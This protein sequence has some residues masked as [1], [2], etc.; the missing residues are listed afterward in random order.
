VDQL[1][2][3]AV[4]AAIMG[5]ILLVG[6]LMTPTNEPAVVE[7]VV[8]QVQTPEEVTVIQEETLELLDPV[9][10]EKAVYQDGTI[11]IAFDASYTSDGLESRLP[12][13]IHNVSGDVINIVW[14]RCSIQLP[15]GNTVKIVS[16]SD[17]GL[18]GG[19]GET[20]SIAPSG[21]LFDAVIPVSEISWSDDGWDLS[22]NVLD[23]GTFTFVLGIERA[24]GLKAAKDACAPVQDGC[25]EQQTMRGERAEQ[26]L[27]AAKRIV[28][29][30][31]GRELVYYTF[32]FIVR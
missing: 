10:S 3:V 14:D 19:M 13:W 16:E 28:P 9:Y 12:F 29:L 4:V 31:E 25:G 8:S 20:I 30:C 23:Q 6:V 22:V 26:L 5:A 27:E 1:G 15:E 2:K 21:D 11:R 7:P 24:T 32:R 17:M 18:F